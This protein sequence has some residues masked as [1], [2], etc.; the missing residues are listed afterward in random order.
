[1]SKVSNADRQTILYTDGIF[2]DHEVLGMLPARLAS[3]NYVCVCVCAGQ[4]AELLYLIL[5]SPAWDRV[6]P[7]HT[8][9][10]DMLTIARDFIL[11]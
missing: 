3:L 2:Y 4:T 8:R 10:N 1:M 6:H 11:H 7:L 9:K 5:P